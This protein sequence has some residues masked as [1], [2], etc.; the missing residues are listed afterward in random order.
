MAWLDRFTGLVGIVIA[1]IAVMLSL[2]AVLLQRRQQRHTAF[3]QIQDVLMTADHQRG[4]WLLWDA[5]ATGKLPEIG[6]SDYY[7]INRALGMLNL[8]ALYTQQGLVPRRWVLELWHHPLAQMDSAVSLM[9]RERVAV[10]GW[11]PWPQLD[12]L[13]REAAGYRS[14]E[15]C[16][17][18]PPGPPES[19]Q[20]RP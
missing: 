5:A 11:R 4:R 13:I 2:L 10:A 15:G 17:V 6:S 12:R 8:L 16:C 14:T 1:V 19:S 3:Q 9:M 18:E 7:L 20:P